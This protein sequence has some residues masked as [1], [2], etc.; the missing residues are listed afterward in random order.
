MYEKLKN[1]FD[2]YEERFKEGFLLTTPREPKD[3][4]VH[5]LLE[6]YRT[7]ITQDPCDDIT[8]KDMEAY[9]DHRK[10]SC[11]KAGNFQTRWGNEIDIHLLGLMEKRN[12]YVINKVEND[13]HLELTSWYDP[14]EMETHDLKR[15]FYIF[16]YDFENSHYCA[17]VNKSDQPKPCVKYFLSGEIDCEKCKK[18]FIEV[19]DLGP[20]MDA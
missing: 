20:D 3:F 6:N 12:I 8:R 17:V 15:K 5:K 2:E 13:F 4:F 19:Q 7:L 9:I 16:Y 11:S 18:K 10:F 1:I 14:A